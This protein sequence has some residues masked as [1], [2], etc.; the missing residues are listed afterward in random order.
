MVDGRRAHV[1]VADD[2][3]LAP[4]RDQ[5]AHALLEHQVVVH[6]V[7]ESRVGSFVRAVQVDQHE[8]AK[9]EHERA[10]FEV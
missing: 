6:L 10:S 9:V 7:R 4:R 2:D 5:P 8:E 3:H 1:Q